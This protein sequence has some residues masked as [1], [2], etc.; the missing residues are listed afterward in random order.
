MYQEH[1]EEQ[2]RNTNAFRKS[3]IGNMNRNEKIR[4]YNFTRNSI[5]DHRIEKGSRQVSDIVALLTGK[6]G[7]EVFHSLRD[8]LAREH[9]IKSLDEFL[10][11]R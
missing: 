3:Q 4:T 11:S 5:I 2:I 1:Y 10:G 6:L 8:K 7:Y 9:Q